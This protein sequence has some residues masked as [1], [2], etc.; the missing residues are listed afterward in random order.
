MLKGKPCRLGRRSVAAFEAYFAPPKKRGRPSK[1]RRKRKTA[2]KAKEAATTNDTSVG[3]M[4]HNKLEGH[5]AK[6]VRQ[7]SKRTNWDVGAAKELRERLAQSW[8]ARN[9][10]Y[11]EGETFAAFCERNGINRHVLKRF[12]D[13][14]EDKQPG[15][16]GRPTLLSNSVMRH[17]CESKSLCNACFFFFL[18][19][20]HM[21]A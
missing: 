16:R 13:R 19:A 10:L 20:Y 6:K 12:L 5:V 15:S 17:L 4:V 2:K 11:N 7:K 3:K 18:H 9:D 1:K 14:P 8:T 21:I